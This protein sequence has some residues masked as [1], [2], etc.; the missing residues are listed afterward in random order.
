M[1]NRYKV[2]HNKIYNYRETSLF[3]FI[4]CSLFVLSPLYRNIWKG[5]NRK[6]KPWRKAE[7]D[8]ETQPKEKKCCFHMCHFH[9]YNTSNQFIICLLVYKSVTVLAR[10]WWTDTQTLSWQHWQSPAAQQ[11]LQDGPAAFLGPVPS[12]GWDTRVE[13]P[14][15]QGG[16]YSN[17]QEVLLWFQEIPQCFRLSVWLSDQL[18]FLKT[19]QRF[20]MK[21]RDWKKR[22]EKEDEVFL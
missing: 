22:E 4:F 10:R 2:S 21:A 6:N 20:I 3:L 5:I 17:V 9:H 18:C 16:G 15:V 19:L 11:N 1:L 14:V 13:Q 8:Y 7:R 12:A